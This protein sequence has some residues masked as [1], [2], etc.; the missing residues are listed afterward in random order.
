M[1]RFI[2]L[3]VLFAVLFAVLSFAVTPAR[4][5]DAY[6]PKPGSPERKAI[7]DAMRPA[8]IKHASKPLPKPIVFKVDFMKVEGDFAGFAGI[9][10]FADGSAVEGYLPDAAYFMILQRIDGKWRVVVEDIRGDVPS[11]A[12]VAAFRRK[13]P[14]GTPEGVLPTSWR[15][16]AGQ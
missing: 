15:R 10:A 4:A 6:T 13:L 9:P 7:C 2:R 1:T 11:D 8:T 5:G 14:A 3:P 12:E 16:T